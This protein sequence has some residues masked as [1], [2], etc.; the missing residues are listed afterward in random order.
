MT[1]KHEVLV[2]NARVQYKFAL[3]RNITVLRGDSAT[4]KTTLIDMIAANQTNGQDSGVF[5]QCDKTCTVLTAMNW[6]LNL[7]QIKDSIVFIDEGDAFVKTR[8]FAR[9]AQG[10][11]NYYVIATR[12]SLF[13]LP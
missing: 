6:Q 10:S 12:A 9:A 5:L 3:E 1:G 11:D 7:G 8:E 2:R 4:G 13:D